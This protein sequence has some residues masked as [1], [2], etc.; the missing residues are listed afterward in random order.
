VNL[1]SNVS[2]LTPSDENQ[3]NLNLQQILSSKDTQL[4][5]AI[6]YLESH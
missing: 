2:P 1:N 6:R 4:V 3:G 5:G